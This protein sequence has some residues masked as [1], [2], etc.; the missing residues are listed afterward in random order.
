MDKVIE[1]ADLD[2]N[3]ILATLGAVVGDTV[4]ITKAE[5]SQE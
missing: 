4:A 5:T 2:A 1:Q 3:P